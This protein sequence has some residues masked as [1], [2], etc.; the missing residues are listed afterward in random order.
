MKHALVLIGML[1]SA[2]LL[3]AWMTPYRYIGSRPLRV[4]RFTGVAE[5]L[6]SDGWKKMQPVPDPLSGFGDPR[7]FADSSATG[8][9]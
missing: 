3:F 2:A 4:S 1:L 8:T 9:P 6:T 7:E 5:Q